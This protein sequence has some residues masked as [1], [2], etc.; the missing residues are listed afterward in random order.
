MKNKFKDGDLIK[1]GRGKNIYRFLGYGNYGRYGDMRIEQ[2]ETNM[3]YTVFSHQAD[4][5]LASSV[6]VEETNDLFPIY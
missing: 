3:V 2:T 5:I 1:R 6:V 4:W